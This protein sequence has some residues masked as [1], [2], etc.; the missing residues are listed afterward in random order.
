MDPLA[1][2]LCALGRTVDYPKPDDADV[3]DEGADNWL[4]LCNSTVSSLG[5]HC[6]VC[7]GWHGAGQ[8]HKDETSGFQGEHE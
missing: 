5:W 3:N 2:A 1:L 8:R 4:L 7:N 6:V